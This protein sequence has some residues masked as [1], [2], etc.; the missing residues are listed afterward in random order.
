M[1]VLASRL[2]KRRTPLFRKRA[3]YACSFAL[4]L[5][6]LAVCWY[7]HQSNSYQPRP[8]PIA[9]ARLPLYV[10]PMNDALQ[11]S[12]SN[13]QDSNAQRIKREG[14]T[15][16][17]TWFGDWNTDVTADVQTY[18]TSAVTAHALPV[19]VAY[20]IPK[21]DCGG[22]SSGGAHDSGDYLKWIQNF[23]SGLGSNQAVVVLEPDAAAGA[24]CLT[25]TERSDR[26]HMI[27]TAVQLLKK[28]THAMVYVDA[29][30]PQ[31]Q[32]VGEITKRLKQSGVAEADGFSL[33]VSNYISTAENQR[34]GDALS[35]R[36]KGM[37]YIIDS[38]RNG[39]AIILGKQ[40]CNARDAVL[41][42][43]PT[44]HT[45]D[46]NN[47]ALLWVKIPW[48]SG[49]KCNGDPAAGQSF[50]QYA[51]QLAKNTGW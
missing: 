34:Y 28:D 26:Y 27:A 48:E 43:L 21:R 39:K 22:Y 12:Q 24:D 9:D 16:T 8:N 15:P 11:Y 46:A 40:W 4:L 19:L 37:H 13:A 50:W 6:V 30:N 3:I 32:T 5:L 20:N 18:V 29:G 7:V 47:D 31:W 2:Q 35:K 49:G 14:E 10:D 45:G 51:I 23:S 1:Y 17:A 36:L 38:S 25:S 41:G 44:V 42:S 33:N